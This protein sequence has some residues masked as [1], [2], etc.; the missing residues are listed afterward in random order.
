MGS[1]S[2]CLFGQFDKIL[3]ISDKEAGVKVQKTGGVAGGE[4]RCGEVVVGLLARDRQSLDILS[5]KKEVKLSASETPGAEEGKGEEDLRCSSLLTVCQ[6]HLGLST[7]Q[8][9]KRQGWSSSVFCQSGLGCG[10]YCE[11]T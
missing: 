8:K 10:T 1:E 5:V 3:W 4:G 9:M 6:S 2:N 11:Q 7:C